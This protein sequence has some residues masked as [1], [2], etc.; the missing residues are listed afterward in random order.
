MDIIDRVRLFFGL[1]RRRPEGWEFPIVS[2]PALPAS[3][4]GAELTASALQKW[5]TLRDALRYV[6]ADDW[7]IEINRDLITASNCTLC[8]AFL[9]E[10]TDCGTCPL[11]LTGSYCLA[12]DSPWAQARDAIFPPR[13]KPLR[14]GTR[15]RALNRMVRALE[16]ADQHAAKHLTDR[17]YDLRDQHRSG[18]VSFTAEQRIRR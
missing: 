4:T 10:A 2:L 11:A 16:R 8:W 9:D 13:W 3:F 14:L 15:L 6:R 1:P 17:T 7:A 12:G 18:S 5:R